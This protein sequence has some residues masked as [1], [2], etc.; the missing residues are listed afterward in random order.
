VHQTL[1]A[2][3]FYYDYGP[4]A[5][6]EIGKEKVQ[7]MDYAY[8]IN[9]WIK[10]MNAS[11]QLRGNDIGKDGNGTGYNPSNNMIH[12]YVALDVLAYT[13]G[14]FKDDYKPITTAP[15]AN[16]FEA[17]R[18]NTTGTPYLFE[19]TAGNLYNGN[20][21]STVISMEGLSTLGTAYKYDQLQRLKKSTTFEIANTSNQNNWSGIT[22][23]DNF[24]TSYTYDKNGNFT[25]LQRKI[26]GTAMDNFTYNYLNIGS[27]TSNRLGHVSDVVLANSYTD[28][29]DAQNPSGNYSYDELGQLV[30]DQQEMIANIEWR[31]GDKKIKKLTRPALAG[32]KS[33]MEFV[34]NPM[35]QR[36]VKIEKTRT[37]NVLDPES[38]WK[39][40]Y[41]TYDAN[42]Q[43]MATYAVKLSSTVNRATLTEQNI[44][45]ASRLG[46]R[47]KDVRLYE[48]GTSPYVIPD[49][50]QNTL[51]NIAYEITNYLG[52]VNVVITDRKLWVPA[53]GAFK[54]CTLSRTDYFPFGMEISSRT[55][56]G[57]YRFGYTG[58][59]EN[60]EINGN[61]NSYDFGNRQYDPRIGRWLSLDPLKALYPSMSP[62][63]YAGNT[64]IAAKD[65]DGRLIIFVN[66]FDG[67]VYGRI[68]KSKKSPTKIKYWGPSLIQ[69]FKRTY[70]DNNDM[71]VNGSD[72]NL[73]ASMA[74]QRYDL[75]YEYVMKNLDKI[76]KEANG[77]TI[78][79]VSHSMGSAYSEG[80]ISALVEK[81]FTVEEVVHL[82]ACDA[83]DIVIGSNPVGPDLWNYFQDETYAK[84]KNITRYQIGIDRDWTLFGDWVGADRYST[85]FERMIPG[86][87]RYGEINAE[88]KL[89]GNN[90]I[91]WM[92]YRPEKAIKSYNELNFHDWTKKNGL[93]LNA[94]D[95]L[96]NKKA[97][98]VSVDNCSGPN[99][100]TNDG[101]FKWN[102]LMFNSKSYTNVDKKNPGNDFNGNEECD[103]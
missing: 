15:L 65:P 22:A 86:V 58:K 16:A 49:V 68:D 102:N 17:A 25:N 37:A 99:W 21:S 59:E 9:G 98:S 29:I 69:G 75:G 100:K 8:T 44:Y 73:G 85:E 89:L 23:T 11:R 10:G 76:K 32:N 82:S 6:V 103:D 5:R 79:I 38:S 52:N 92:N 55:N 56:V 3:Y 93:V 4:L 83:A 27:A 43:V 48:N 35:G 70:Q 60:N 30:Y 36:V 97:G 14:Y 1:Q 77:E 46:M 28:D 18:Y 62:Y 96:K 87:T 7:G 84:I 33:D 63:C 13:V 47:R 50:Q 45:G 20:I 19:T 39:Y 31:S 40:T 101:F 78:K 74:Y 71:Y 64:P 57:T 12:R 34:Y 42:G 26:N 95:E 41:Y 54:A 2:Q 81:G 72:G 61:G 90:F 67:G 51:G 66:G 24:G 91:K 88:Y 53:T 80:M 94:L